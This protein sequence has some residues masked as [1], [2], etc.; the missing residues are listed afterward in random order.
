MVNY[1]TQL[2]VPAFHALNLVIM[3]PL[4]MFISISQ[5]MAFALTFPLMIIFL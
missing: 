3:S 2:I 1:K 4:H 5:T